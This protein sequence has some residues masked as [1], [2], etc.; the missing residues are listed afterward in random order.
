M[1]KY[2]S[3]YMLSSKTLTLRT[4]TL[5]DADALITQMNTIDSETKFL[6]RE[7][8]EFDLTREQEQAFI[9]RSL[10]NP[11]GLFIVGE[12]DGEIV[13]NCSV[14]I[15]SQRQ[16]YRHR[17]TLGIAVNKAYWHNG[18]GKRMMQIS[19]DWCKEKG[20]EQLELDVVAENERALALYQ[21]LGFKICGTKEHALKYGD[22]TYADEYFMILH[23]DATAA[24]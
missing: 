24:K 21:S 4:P 9:K 23:L 22:H 3:E 16:R 10:E 15:I 11:N 7:P 12:V 14:G 17:A 5:E 19:I 8:G 18:I 13:A 1:N 20:V 2:H 6:A